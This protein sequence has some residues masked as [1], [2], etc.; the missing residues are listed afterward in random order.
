MNKIIAIVG[1][2]GAGKSTAREYFEGIGCK[3]VY[4]GG[5]T[6]DVMNK[7]GIEINPENERTTRENI[8][9]EYG[10]G[11]YAI[12]SL[13]KI[14]EYL[15]EGNVVIDDLYSWDELKILQEKYENNIISLCIVADR[16]IRYDRLEKRQIRPFTNEQAMT[17]DITQIENL[18]QG[19]PIAYADYYIVNNSSLEEYK[20]KLNEVKDKIFKEE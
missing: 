9:K 12:L 20:E 17:R 19:G 15:K 14:E 18:A 10:M 8:R 4:F 7:K 3:N 11:A 1:M 2:S 5:I 13:P 6:F 16:K